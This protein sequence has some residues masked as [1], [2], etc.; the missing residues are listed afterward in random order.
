[1]HQIC[2]NSKTLDVDA[3]NEIKKKVIRDYNLFINSLFKGYKNDYNYILHE[4][5]FIDNYL[6]LDNPKTLYEHFMNYELR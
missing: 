3:L 2:Y 5:S 6:Y 4:I 1:M